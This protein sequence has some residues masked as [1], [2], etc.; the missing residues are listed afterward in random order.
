MAQVRN[1]QWSGIWAV[2]ICKASMTHCGNEYGHAKN[3]MVTARVRDQLVADLGRDPLG[4]TIC[5][6]WCSETFS[7]RTTY[8]NLSN[9][10][11]DPKS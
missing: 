5:R 2:T 6:I 10:Q 1:P 8:M 7:S 9:V 4:M 3:E 11:H